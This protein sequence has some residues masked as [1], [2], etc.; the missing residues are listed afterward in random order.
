[1]NERRARWAEIG[2]ET[3]TQSVSAALERFG[4]G[5]GQLSQNSLSEGEVFEE[6]ASD[7][8]GNLA[9]LARRR[10]HNVHGIIERGLFHFQA[11]C[12]EEQSEW[13]S[14]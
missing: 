8:V 4:I 1:M 7:F 6:V 3:Y 12:A 14:M 13:G 11:E 9:H 5:T 2:I 10:G